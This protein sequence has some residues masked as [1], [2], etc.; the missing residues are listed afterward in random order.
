MLKKTIPFILF[1]LF[2]SLLFSQPSHWRYLN[3]ESG[4]Y[5]TEIIPLHYPQGNRPASVNNQVLVARMDIGGIC[6]STD[7]GYSWTNIDN[8]FRP[9]GPWQSEKSESELSVQGVAIRPNTADPVNES[10]TMVICWG[11]YV[12]L[13]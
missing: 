10:E 5:V 6:R 4:G 2:T 8:F 9:T 1:F 3:Y 7:N 12:R 13:Y 11:N